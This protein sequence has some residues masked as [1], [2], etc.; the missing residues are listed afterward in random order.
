[1]RDLGNIENEFGGPTYVESGEK[2]KWFAAVLVLHGIPLALLNFPRRTCR[3]T[4][5]ATP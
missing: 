2:Q 3:R 1:L 5:W 4:R